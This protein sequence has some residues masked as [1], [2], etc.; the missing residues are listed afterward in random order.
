MKEKDLDKDGWKE[1]SV[2][3][4]WVFEKNDTWFFV[5]ARNNYT[6]QP[7]YPKWVRA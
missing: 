1:E 4:T 2:G 6:A 3:V 7:H 5:F